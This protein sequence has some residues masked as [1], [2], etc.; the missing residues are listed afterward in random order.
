MSFIVCLIANHTADVGT[1]VPGF[2]TV[3]VTPEPGFVGVPNVN[4]K[5]FEVVYCLSDEVKPTFPEVDSQV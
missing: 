3:Q 5:P 4:S 2:I 1:A